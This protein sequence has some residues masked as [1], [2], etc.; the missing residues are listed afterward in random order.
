L[1]QGVILAFISYRE[2]IKIYQLELYFNTGIVIPILC[3]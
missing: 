3:L 1:K 2:F